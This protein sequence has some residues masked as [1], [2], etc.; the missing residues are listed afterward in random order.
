MNNIYKSENEL[1][2]NE[3]IKMNQEWIHMG[4]KKTIGIIGNKK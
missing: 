4:V 2:Y 1:G 3:W